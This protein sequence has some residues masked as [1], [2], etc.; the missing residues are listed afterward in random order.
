VD[1]DVVIDGVHTPESPGERSARTR[2]HAAARGLKFSITVDNDGSNWK[3]LNNHYWLTPYVVDRRGRVRCRC[4]ATCAT[5]AHLARRRPAGSS[6]HSCSSLR[7]LAEPL[8][9]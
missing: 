7:E 6:T 2:A 5:K 8:S 1:K 3:A 9:E 4:E